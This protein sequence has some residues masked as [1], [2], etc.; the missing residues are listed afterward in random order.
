MF[1]CLPPPPPPFPFLPRSR[2]LG[3]E[4]KRDTRL[5]FCLY[6]MYPHGPPKMTQQFVIQLFTPM[7]MGD[8]HMITSNFDPKLSHY[9]LI[10]FARRTLPR[11]RG[12]YWLFCRR[13]GWCVKLHSGTALM[14]LY[15]FFHHYCTRNT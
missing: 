6:C 3:H 11:A 4:E 7:N 12:E 8:R 15:R 2:R 5:S 1:S 14:T 10:S 9:S 13:L